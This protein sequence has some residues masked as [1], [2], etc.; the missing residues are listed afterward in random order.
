M[1]EPMEELETCGLM[2]LE[3][4]QASLVLTLLLPWD[5]HGLLSRSVQKM[6]RLLVAKV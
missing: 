5:G 1:E 3:A 6:M 4:D 2:L